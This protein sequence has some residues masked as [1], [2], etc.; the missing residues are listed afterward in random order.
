LPSS[1]D[2]GKNEVRGHV[3]HR[4]RNR[5]LP[6]CPYFLSHWAKP[7]PICF[8]QNGKKMTRVERVKKPPYFFT[9]NSPNSQVKC[10][11][12]CALI[13]KGEYEIRP[14][15]TNVY[16]YTRHTQKFVNSHIRPLNQVYTST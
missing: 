8:E 14:Q 11:S 12:W 7:H 5:R 16:L 10:V 2:T 9:H 13:F 1:N 6:V 15:P 3:H 4:F